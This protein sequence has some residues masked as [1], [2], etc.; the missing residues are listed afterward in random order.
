MEV[1]A[2]AMTSLN[3]RERQLLVDPTADLAAQPRRLTPAPWILP[4]YQPLRTARSGA[5][6]DVDE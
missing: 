4:L 2:Q 5:D 3:G 1:R 6:P